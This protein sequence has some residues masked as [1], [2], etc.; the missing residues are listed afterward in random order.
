MYF[1]K[2]R[3]RQYRFLPCQD[4]DTTG[5][6]RVFSTAPGAIPRYEHEGKRIPGGGPMTR[7]YR[8]NYDAEY[9]ACR[10]LRDEGWY[11]SYCTG[12]LA[13]PDIFAVGPDGCKLIMVRS[14]RTPV[15][16]ARAVFDLYERELERMRSFTGRNGL[17]PEAWI[18]SPPDG[19]KRYRVYPGGIWR[20]FA[21]REDECSSDFFRHSRNGKD[22]GPVAPWFSLIGPFSP[23]DEVEEPVNFPGPAVRTSPLIQVKRH[24]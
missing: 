14:S 3:I 5:R 13:P 19:W 4:T 1:K 10:I 21:G 15:P 6:S 18:R 17:V 16:D 24:A 2:S 11:A 7:R 22:P 23:E 8:K 20:I 9:E 12:A